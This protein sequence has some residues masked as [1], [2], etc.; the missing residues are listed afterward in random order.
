MGNEF[1]SV[2]QDRPLRHLNDRLADS[3]GRL[4]EGITDRDKLHLTV[5]TY[6]LWAQ[7][8]RPRLLELLG[9]RSQTDQPPP[10]P[11]TPARPDRCRA[12]VDK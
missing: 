1:I 3:T 5:D 4:L 8:L 2:P 11:P 10:P 7:A 6:Q 12:L 9:P